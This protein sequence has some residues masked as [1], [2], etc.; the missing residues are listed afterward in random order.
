V[1]IASIAG[2]APA[3]SSDQSGGGT[4]AQSLPDHSS[5][6][7]SLKM[8]D[9]DGLQ[10]LIASK[11]DKV[12]VLDVW[13]TGCPPCM[14]SFPGLVALH[15]KYG[16]DRLAC[17]SLSLDYEGIGKPDDVTP[18]VIEFL[19]KQQATFDNVLSSEEPE[20]IDKKLGIVSIPAVLVFD[21]SGS[22]RKRF[23]DGSVEKQR[24]V[25]EQVE[26]LVKELLAGL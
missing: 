24:P 22:L 21:T 2:C 9:Y 23:T 3:V 15:R 5:D 19:R 18:A 17:I 6:R 7:V 1:L 10:Q 16:N 8:L 26:A 12:V 25:Y 20:A 14:K 11:R 13:S 4:S